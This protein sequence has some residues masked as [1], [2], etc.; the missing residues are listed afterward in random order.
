MKKGNQSKTMFLAFDA[1]VRRTGNGMVPANYPENPKLGRWVS[2]IRYLRKVGEL[3]PT[4]VAELDSMGFVWSAGE[5]LWESMFRDLLSFRE[6]FGHCDVPTARDE[7][8]RLGNWVASQRHRHKLGNLSAKRIRR[9]ADIGFRW[10]LYGSNDA[11]SAEQ[12]RPA[13][14]APPEER[15]YRIGAEG[16]VQYGIGEIPTKLQRYLA[17]HGDWPPYILLPTTRTRF[18]LMSNDRGKVRRIEW[19]GCGPLPE[20]VI[21]FVNENGCLPPQT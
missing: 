6:K 5:K 7:S 2:R 8:P 19:K 18:I 16:Y 20:D 13:A 11:G 9:L 3:E 21:E 15:L 10:N 17:R 14:E 1:Y 4:F 12:K